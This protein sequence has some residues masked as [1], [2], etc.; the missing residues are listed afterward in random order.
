[1]WQVQKVLHV[2]SNLNQKGY[3]ANHSGCQLH[4]W[5]CN[6][7]ASINATFGYPGQAPILGCQTLENADEFSWDT[8]R[9][10]VDK[11]WKTQM[12]LAGH[13]PILGRQAFENADE[14]QRDTHRSL[15]FKPWKTQIQPSFSSSF[16][17][18]IPLSARLHVY[19]KFQNHS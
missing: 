2:S 8:H 12:S 16:S 13:A 1:M 7:Y 10:L 6:Q 14:V 18:L 11:P 5:P 17:I 19:G 15:V 3:S 9:S 4:M